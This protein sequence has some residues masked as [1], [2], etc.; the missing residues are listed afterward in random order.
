MKSAL[1]I[2]LAALCQILVCNF[3]QAVEAADIEP[4][5]LFLLLAL[6]TLPLARH[7]DAEVG[8]GRSA[9]QVPHLGILAQVADNHDFIKSSHVLLL[10]SFVSRFWADDRTHWLLSRGSGHRSCHDL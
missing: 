9:W 8:D 7:G 6:T 3:S 5:G 10:L 1:N 4:L 2:D